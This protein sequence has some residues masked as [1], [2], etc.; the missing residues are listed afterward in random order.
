MGA[1]T[2]ALMSA[3]GGAAS[4]VAALGSLFSDKGS[5]PQAEKPIA[6]PDPVAQDAKMR[7]KAALMSAQQMTRASTVLSPTSEKLG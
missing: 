7:R 1:E 6:M 3:V 2:L 4:G 5:A